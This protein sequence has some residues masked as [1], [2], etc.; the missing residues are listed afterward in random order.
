MDNLELLDVITIED[1]YRLPESEIWNRVT[2]I[3]NEEATLNNWQV[4]SIN[5]KTGSP[6][7]SGDY[8]RYEYE[9]YGQAINMT[10]KSLGSSEKMETTSDEFVARESSL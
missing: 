1:K 6:I 7:K 2:D 10:N 3:T 5:K 8:L 9:V 4:S